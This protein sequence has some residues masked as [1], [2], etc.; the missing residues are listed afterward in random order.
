VPSQPRRPSPAPSPTA[1]TAGSASSRHPACSGGQHTTAGHPAM[2]DLLR[3]N[4]SERAGSCVHEIP[5]SLT[6]MHRTG[7]EGLRHHNHVRHSTVRAVTS[8]SD[9]RI[10]ESRSYPHNMPTQHTHT[11]RMARI[12]LGNN[13]VPATGQHRHDTYITEH[14]GLD[15]SHNPQ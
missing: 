10:F 7:H 2:G 13:N 5:R 11:A 3:A 1:E 8:Y 6:S 12:T 14:A 9:R 4:A 15:T